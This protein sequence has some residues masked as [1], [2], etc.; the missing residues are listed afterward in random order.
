V[1]PEPDRVQPRETRLLVNPP[2]AGVKTVQVG[3][4]DAA[5]LFGGLRVQ[6]GQER[7]ANVEVGVVE[8]T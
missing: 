3:R 6:R 1:L 7:L 8:L 5:F 4:A 2:V